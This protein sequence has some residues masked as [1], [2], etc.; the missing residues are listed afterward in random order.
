MAEENGSCGFPHRWD[1]TQRGSS[2]PRLLAGIRGEK[3]MEAKEPAAVEMAN[4]GDQFAGGETF[5]GF[6]GCAEI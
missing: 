4:V 6:F 5:P 2:R 1:A 3:R